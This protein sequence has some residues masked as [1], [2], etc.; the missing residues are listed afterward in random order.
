MSNLATEELH[1]KPAVL[2]SATPEAGESITVPEK[3]LREWRIAL[4]IGI[5]SCVYLMAFRRITTLNPDEGV[6]LQAAQRILHGEVPY[7]DFFSLVTPGS[8]YW[9]ALL[10][11]VFGDSILVARTALVTYGGLFSLL[12]Y[13]LARRVCSRKNA[14]LGACLLTVTCLPYYFSFEHNWD[15]T[16]WAC[17]ALYCAVRFLEE[18]KWLWAFAVGLLASLTCLFEQS[19]G[20]GLVL[21]LAVGFLLIT[22]MFGGLALFTRKRL[23]ALALGT[24]LPL[25][26]TLIYFGAKHSLAPMLADWIWPL[27]HY[28]SVNRVPYGYLP[29]SPSE[30]H[31]IHTGS[32]LW[33]LF[34]LFVLSPSF[35]VPALPILALVLLGCR[36]FAVRARRAW[37]QENAYYILVC[38]CIFGLW[39]STLVARPELSHMMY[40]APIL[41]LVLCWVFEGKAFGGAFLP[42]ARRVIAAYVLLSF[43]GF[44]L[45]LLANAASLH[46]PLQTRRGILRTIKQDTVAAYVQAHVPEGGRMFV[47]PYQPLYYYLTGTVNP[48]SYDFLY[49]GYNTPGQFKKAKQELEMDRT[50]AILLTPFFPSIQMTAFPGTPLGVLARGDPMVDFI[51]SRY[52]PCKTLPSAQGFSYV[53]L[54]RKDLPCPKDSDSKQKQ[55]R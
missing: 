6:S 5:L 18:R 46:Q 34:A 15:S 1:T 25:L 22:C 8:Y 2:R 45:A 51:F 31:T 52:R 48:T 7:R 12:M 13:L 36:V 11:R 23:A 28:N 27:K 37:D 21:G 32:L 38:S 19:K 35:L 26:V 44:G 3:S 29:L 55:S 53:F 24:V 54:I 42:A 47:Y 16:M 40:L 20:G 43:S 4:S 41:Y 49:M 33:R 17:L 14:A 30:W 10:F 50:P 9:T 39:L